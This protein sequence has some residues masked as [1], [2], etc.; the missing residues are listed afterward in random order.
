MLP[1]HFVC[2][3]LNEALTAPVGNPI[4]KEQTRS[5]LIRKNRAL[6]KSEQGQALENGWISTHRKEQMGESRHVG[7]FGFWLP[8]TL[9][10][11]HNTTTTGSIPMLAVGVPI[12]D[13]THDIALR[14]AKAGFIVK[15]FCHVESLHSGAFLAISNVKV[16]S[17]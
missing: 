9:K 8:A 16:Q 1:I 17:N 3:V 2:W 5:R 11:R 7:R 14:R 10:S 12:C 4:S 15:T 6:L 13:I